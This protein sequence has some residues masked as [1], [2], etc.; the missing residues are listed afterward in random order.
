MVTRH[1]AW[2]ALIKAGR[3]PANEVTSSSY[4]NRETA[5][6]TRPTDSWTSREWRLATKA[7]SLNCDMKFNENDNANFKEQFNKDIYS[8]SVQISFNLTA[9]NY[10]C[11]IE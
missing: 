6:N 7:D 9:K 2:P 8:L 3:L 4:V 5:W 10:T 1:Q 11:E